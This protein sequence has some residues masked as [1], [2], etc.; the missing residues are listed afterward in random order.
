MSHRIPATC[1][2]VPNARGEINADLLAFIKFLIPILEAGPSNKGL[3]RINL[4][5]TASAHV[6]RYSIL[7][8]CPVR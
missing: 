4:I 5:F 6:P 1:T 3:P 2:D 8:R 7:T